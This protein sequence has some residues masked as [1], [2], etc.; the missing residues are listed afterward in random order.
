MD[1]TTE[2]LNGQQVKIYWDRTGDVLSRNGY[3][4]TERLE[5]VD[6]DLNNYEA[7]GIICCDEIQRVEDLEEIIN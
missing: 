2:Y 5:G 1:I 7:C 4:Y 3:E 6:D